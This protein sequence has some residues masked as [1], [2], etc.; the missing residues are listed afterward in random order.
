M[1][2]ITKM[3]TKMFNNIIKIS[4]KSNEIDLMNDLTGINVRLIDLKKIKK[5]FVE[6]IRVI[7]NKDI[8]F[9]NK[10]LEKYIEFL[11]SDEDDK[12]L[13][14]FLKYQQYIEDYDELI[15]YNEKEEIIEQCEQS[16]INSI[17]YALEEYKVFEL[18][19]NLM[20]EIE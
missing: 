14:I 8:K 17:Y 13:M 3:T 2:F 7:R 19:E 18:C 5:K 4:K 16:L 11:N 10:Q 9:I 12:Q 20:E 15:K 6:K 1:L